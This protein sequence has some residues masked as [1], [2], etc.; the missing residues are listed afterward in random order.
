[1]FDN[2]GENRNISQTSSPLKKGLIKNKEAIAEY[3]EALNM[4]D[5]QRDSHFSRLDILKR[6][7]GLGDGLKTDSEI[8]TNL[9][10]DEVATFIDWKSAFNSFIV[11]F[12]IL[13]ILIIGAFAYLSFLE[14]EEEK[15]ANIYNED[16]LSTSLSIK[17]EEQT[18]DKGLILQGKIQAV[19]YLIDNHI[20]WTNFFDFIEENTLESVYYDKFGGN[21]KTQFDFL[22]TADKNYFNAT[23]QIKLFKENAYIQEVEVS[24]LN[25]K[26]D[27]DSTQVTFSINLQVDPEILYKRKT[28]N[29]E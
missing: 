3:D 11:Y 23:E 4:E 2:Q 27:G 28:E 29:N 7:L 8:K 1:M 24:S 9:I 13:L 26:E 21:T 10:D 20:Y 5:S 15:K 12:S 14:N 17:K 16:I 19:E 18:I 22:A 25:L 6:K